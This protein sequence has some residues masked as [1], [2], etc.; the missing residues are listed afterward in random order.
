MSRKPR[1]HE[2]GDI[3]H[4]MSHGID[5]LNLFE[6]EQDCTKFIEILEKNFIKFDCHCYAFTLMK[7]HYHLLLRPSGD[8]FSKMMRNINN[9]FARYINKTR[10]RRG[11]VF[12]DRFKSIPTRD[13]NYVK[14][15][16]LYIHTNPLRSQ[17]HEVS[18]LKE[19]DAYSWSSHYALKQKTNPYS[20]LNCDY[21][22]ALF[23][24]EGESSYKNYKEE[25]QN[26]LE[27]ST[28][29][30]KAWEI[31]T[32]YKRPEPKIPSEVF[33]NEAEWVKTKVK[34]AEQIRIFREKVARQPGIVQQLLDESCKIF[35]LSRDAFEQNMRKHTKK[36]CNV[37]K[38][39]SYWSIEIA[40][41]SGVFVG[42]ILHRSNSAVLRSSMLGKSL[43]VKTPFPIKV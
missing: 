21:T 37:I 19:L 18:S 25:I 12:F 38:L 15:L 7:S 20:W 29:K 33:K 32:D 43:G 9:T 2:T 3:H 36:I 28:E 22:L 27:E 34:K 42:H 23:N 4:V 30:F 14:N 26:Y 16:V 8:N 39:F 35:S 40:G 11:Y 6:T 31:D 1:L 10:K 5:T 41:F 13:L 17:K 24:K